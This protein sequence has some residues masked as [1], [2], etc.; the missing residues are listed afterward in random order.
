MTFDRPIYGLSPGSQLAAEVVFGLGALLA[1]VY[2]AWLARRG[3]EDL[4]PDGL[5]LRGCP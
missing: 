1:L 5:D 3:G 4:A 2:C